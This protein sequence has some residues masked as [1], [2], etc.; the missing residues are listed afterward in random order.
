MGG[1]I[2]SN[3]NTDSYNERV[4]ITNAMNSFR[5]SY[6]SSQWPTIEDV[7]KMGLWPG[8]TWSRI[9]DSADQ[10]DARSR[11]MSRMEQLSGCCVGVRIYVEYNS[12]TLGRIYTYV[13]IY[14]ISYI[15]NIISSYG[16]TWALGQSKLEVNAQ[17]QMSVLNPWAGL[18]PFVL[19]VL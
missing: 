4:N 10:G 8:R 19:I 3:V 7:G 1:E 14:I 11:R 9:A 12:R 2:H 13:Y 6:L 17:N 5:I 18:W 15:V 16:L